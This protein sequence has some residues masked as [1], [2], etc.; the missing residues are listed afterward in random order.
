MADPTVNLEDITLDPLNL[1]HFQES[2]LEVQVWRLDKIHPEISGNKWFKLKYYLEAGRQQEKK[3]L[4]SFGGPYSNH[5][6][7]LACAAHAHGFT[8]TGLIRGE[9]PVI[10]T[11]AL[12]TARKYG[13]DFQ[14]MSRDEYRNKEDP[15]FLLSLQS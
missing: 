14:F 3:M 8:S 13:M 7:A 4:I 9:S 6:V 12:Y 10:L 2:K 15:G 5:I 1:P 11:P